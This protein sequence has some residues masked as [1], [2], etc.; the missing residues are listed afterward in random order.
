MMMNLTNEIISYLLDSLVN[1]VPLGSDK[2]LAV[3]SGFVEEPRVDLSL[4]V[5]QRHIA[6]Q[7][8]RV[9]YAL[10]HVRVPR[11]VVQHEP[12]TQNQW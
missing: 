6:R 1:K 8:V 9:F 7:D 10:R 2:L 3:F 11:A 5:L 12:W 4:L